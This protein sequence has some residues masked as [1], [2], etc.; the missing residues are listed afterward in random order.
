MFYRY[1]AWN[2]ETHY[3]WTTSEAVAEA[4]LEELNRDGAEYRMEAI[5]KDA[6]DDTG[7]PLSNWT[8]LLTTD[9]TTL[10]D[11]ESA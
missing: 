1:T 5:G 6:T 2:R 4:A 3:G 9:D 7:C 11:F 8:G 10:D